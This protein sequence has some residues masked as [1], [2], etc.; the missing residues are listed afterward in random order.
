LSISGISVTF[1]SRTDAKAS[2]S[3]LLTAV[4]KKDGK[5]MMIEENKTWQLR[6]QGKTWMLTGTG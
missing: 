4:Y 3:Q 1:S 6:K 5:K 2:F